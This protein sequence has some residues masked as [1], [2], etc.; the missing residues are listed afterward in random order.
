MDNITTPHP[1]N[2]CWTKPEV[3]A[4]YSQIDNIYFGYCYI[5][6]EHCL[7]Y[8]KAPIERLVYNAR[9][10]ALIMWNELNPLSNK[11]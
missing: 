9:Q 5:S 4:N 1:C 3:G 8:V 6:C 2:K 11:E 7:Q 10:D